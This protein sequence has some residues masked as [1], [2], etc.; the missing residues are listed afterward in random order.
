VR[1]TFLGVRGS[2]ASPGSDF[3]RYG[4]NTSCIA[5]SASDARPDLVLD[6]GTGLR[7][8]PGLLGGASYTGGILLSHL[9]WDHVQGL[10]FCPAVDRD[11]AVVEVVM[12]AQAGKNGHD[13]LAQHMSPPAFPI[14]PDGLRGAWTFTAAEV[15]QFAF[16]PYQVRATEIAHKGGRTYGYRVEHGGA[17]LAYLPD[18]APVAGVSDDTLETLRD[19]DLLVHDAQFVEAERGIADAFGH[20]TVGDAVDLALQVGARTL[21]LFHH[22]PGRT[23]DALDAIVT[24]LDGRAGRLGSLTV[25]TPREGDVVEL[26]GR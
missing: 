7:G 20:S 15:G 12:P 23:D 1:L 25:I 3:V 26:P 13:L 5:V 14:T 21:A 18:H 24:A 22:G 8:L 9:H 19:V 16:G 4:G 2:T 17:S 10:P 11:D 6:A